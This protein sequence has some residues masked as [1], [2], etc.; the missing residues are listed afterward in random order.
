MAE[1]GPI[2]IHCVIDL[3]E[4]TMSGDELFDDL[5]SQARPAVAPGQGSPRMRE[6]VRDQIELRA[7]DID[8]LI[9]SD[10]PAR[11]IWGYVE[12]LDL[13]VLEDAIKAREGTPGG[14]A[15][16]PRLLL[17]LWLYATSDGVGSARALSRLIEQHDAYRWLAGGV[18][19]NY[20]TLSDF[21]VGQGALLDRLLAE[22]V[23]ALC[24]TGVIDVS[25]LAQ[26]GVRVRAGAGAASFRGR[27]RLEQHLATAREVVA[28]LKREVDENS[29]ASNERMRAARD[30]AARERVERIEAALQTLDKVEAQRE[31][32]K[33]T[34]GKTA[35]KRKEPRA[36]TTDPQARV[37]KMADGGFRPAYN[38]QVVSA[39]GEQFVIDV[40][41]LTTGSDRGLLRPTLEAA[42]ERLGHLPDR[43]LADGGFTSAADIEWAHRAGT[44]IYCPPTQSKH[45]TDPYLPRR[46]DGPG[47][48]AW[49]NRMASSEGQAIYRERSICEC[50]HARWRNWNL[51]RLNVRGTVKVKAVMLWY[52][53]ANNIIQGQRFARIA[54]A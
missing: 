48:L 11:V 28:Q 21:R 54:A 37:M 49:R 18:S 17:A 9:G 46:D 20:H 52:A 24:A 53:L 31:E 23:A 1:G 3:R 10:H 16:A 15:I 51:I 6:P 33:Q 45:G 12:R 36:S 47:V 8:S 50:I 30:R 35:E 27:G 4:R 44:D 40:D 42:G 32:R 14:P 25:T 5:P 29:D 39:A 7:V 38:V 19:V 13:R 2:V 41:P 34:T 43:H 26:D 22:N